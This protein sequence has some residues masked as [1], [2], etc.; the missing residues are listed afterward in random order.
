MEVME[1]NIANL[2]FHTVTAGASKLNYPVVQYGTW[3]G[4]C[5][6]ELWCIPYAQVWVN[7]ETVIL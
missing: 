4:H 5:W 6:T 3:D 1:V 2:S 7:F